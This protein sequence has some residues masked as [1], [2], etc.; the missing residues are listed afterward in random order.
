MGLK[1]NDQNTQY[2]HFT[3]N[4]N[5]KSEKLQIYEHELRLFIFCWDLGKYNL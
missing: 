4:Q 5:R 3:G 2:I 1:V